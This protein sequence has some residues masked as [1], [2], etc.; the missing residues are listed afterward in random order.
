MWYLGLIQYNTDSQ[1]N[2]ALNMPVICDC[3]TVKSLGCVD[4]T[5][6]AGLER[7]YAPWFRLSKAMILSDAG[8]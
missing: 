2:L 1:L 6:H 5:Q 8:S 3:P 4:S 7:Y